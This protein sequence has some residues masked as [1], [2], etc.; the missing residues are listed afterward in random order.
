SG[1]VSIAS[2]AGRGAGDTQAASRKVLSSRPGKCWRAWRGIKV[3]FYHRV[4]E[5]QRYTF[6]VSVSGPLGRITV[7]QLVAF[8]WLAFRCRRLPATPPPELHPGY[9]TLG[10]M[11]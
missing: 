11:S 7:R 10:P 2:T 6:F 4:T 5:A 3:V 8:A 9:A 1:N